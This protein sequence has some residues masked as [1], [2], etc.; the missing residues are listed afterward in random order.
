MQVSI[1]INVEQL[2]VLIKNLPEDQLLK[3]YGEITKTLKTKTNVDK[4]EY[5]DMLLQ[6]PTMSKD[7]YLAF[8]ENRKKFNQWRTS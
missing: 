5:L 8:K 7:Q 6:A 1:D 4:D 2:L 3:L